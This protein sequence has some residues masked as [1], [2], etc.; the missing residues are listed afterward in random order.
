[1]GGAGGGGGKRVRLGCKADGAELRGVQ[2]IVHLS[3]DS[4]GVVSIVKP[5]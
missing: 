2:G 3:L 5:S 4:R 1:L